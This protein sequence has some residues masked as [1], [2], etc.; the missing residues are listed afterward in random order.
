MENGNIKSSVNGKHDKE[1]FKPNSLKYLKYY[2]L[3]VCWIKLN[4]VFQIFG[5]F[6]FLEMRP[7]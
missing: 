3:W 6:P 2:K 4:V 5:L 7:P 1:L